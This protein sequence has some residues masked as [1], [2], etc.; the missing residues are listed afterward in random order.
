MKVIN[1]LIGYKNKKVVQDTDWFSFSLDS[2]ML[3]RFVT[4]NKG[5]KNIL[6]IGTGTAPIPLIL[7]TRTNAKIKA[8]IFFIR[9]FIFCI[10]SK[11][12][13]YQRVWAI[14]DKSLQ[15]VSLL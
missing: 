9:L 7:S 13:A 5:T 4:I 2:V 3:P 1:D 8:L 11:C 14:I 6:D 15:T 10:L 12:I